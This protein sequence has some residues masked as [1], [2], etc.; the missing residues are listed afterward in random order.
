MTPQEFTFCKEVLQYLSSTELTAKNYLFLEPVDTTLFTTYLQYVQRPMDLG[1][2]ATLLSTSPTTS[3]YE[4]V[5]QFFVDIFLCFH[6]AVA[7]HSDKKENSWIVKLAK[8]MIRITQREQK[9]MMK[10]LEDIGSKINTSKAVRHESSVSLQSSV[11]DG[12][13]K[14]V[15]LE[16]APEMPTIATTTDSSNR[17]EKTTSAIKSNTSQ[18][19]SK[20]KITLPLSKNA[21]MSKSS[22]DNGTAEAS[23][24][25]SLQLTSRGKQMPRDETVAAMPSTIA[26]TTQP[27][28]KIR[29]SLGT[30]G[31]VV[32]AKKSSSATTTSS[33][34]Q[35]TVPSKLNTSQI[36]LV[37]SNL[38]NRGAS[39]VSVLE[40]AGGLLPSKVALNPLSSSKTLKKLPLQAKSSETASHDTTTT[41][42]QSSSF[43]DLN[44]YFSLGV[45]INNV[46]DLFTTAFTVSSVPMTRAP[47][48]QCFK[49]LSALIRRNSN[50]AHWFLKPVNDPRLVDDYKAKYVHAYLC[51]FCLLIKYCNSFFVLLGFLNRWI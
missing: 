29:L 15:E 46:D 32:G 24:I 22:S 18:R 36:R 44:T 26:S 8:E 33:V 20:F 51:T 21:P 6:N 38:V 14:S 41:P 28:P 48:E 12:E 5:D 42:I 11:E 37:E 49:V 34:D 30:G 27:P 40:Q 1:T 43:S 2:V 9:K 3:T 50:H 31:G 47:R 25:S 10:K 13:I 4:T 16:S 17:K 23:K 7:F 35:S 19:Q 39:D 45:K